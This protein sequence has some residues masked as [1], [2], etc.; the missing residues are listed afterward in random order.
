MK[1]H[2]LDIVVIGNVAAPN[3]KRHLSPAVKACVEV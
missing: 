2:P 1:I 3:C